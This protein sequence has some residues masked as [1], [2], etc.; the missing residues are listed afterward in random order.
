MLEEAA[1]QTHQAIITVNRSI[2]G[3]LTRGRQWTS[4]G[5][6][7]AIHSSVGDEDFVD[8]TAGRLYGASKSQRES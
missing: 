5:R 3:K 4:K 1:E 7:K 6:G 2:L 8:G